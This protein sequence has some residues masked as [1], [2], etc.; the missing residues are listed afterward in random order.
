MV[1]E[2]TAFDV[3]LQALENGPQRGDVL[4]DLLLRLLRFPRKLDGCG[5]SVGHHRPICGISG[6]G[7]LDKKVR[8][9]PACL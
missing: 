7:E 4:W 6:L 9:E 1:L 2:Q 5:V 3:E 8:G